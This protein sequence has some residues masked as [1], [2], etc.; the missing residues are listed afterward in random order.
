MNDSEGETA[1]RYARHVIESTV[2]NGSYDQPGEKLPKIFE[3]KS[4]VFVTILRFP[5]HE[6]RGCIGF[7]EPV[8]PL[9]LALLNAAVEAAISDP[10]F[11]PVE[12]NELP[13]ITIE[14]SV[15]TPPEPVQSSTP[16]ELPGKI[17]VG[18]DG[19]IVERGRFR[20]LLLPQVAVEEGWDSEEFLSQ[21]CWKA[22]LPED[23]WRYSG[24]RV[25]RFGAELFSEEEPNGKVTRKI[26]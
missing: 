14:V 2:R 1:V 6:L 20:G 12:E 4:G 3:E 22:G 10:R 23:A 26:L 7:P 24:I 11:S 17:T 5:S 15:L 9:R 19:I 8:Y 18:R 16:W 21:T 25:Y 13:A